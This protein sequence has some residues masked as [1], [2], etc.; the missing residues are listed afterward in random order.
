MNR[1]SDLKQLRRI[2][3][4]RQLTSDFQPIVNLRQVALF[5]YEGLIR[6]PADSSLHNPGSLFDCAGRHNLI[7]DLER[8][9]RDVSC[10]RFC[11]QSVNGKL[12]LNVSPVSISD[13]GFREH[14]IS[15]TLA[16]L[17]MPP[18]RMV[19]EIT[20]QYPLDDYQAIREATRY[21]KE[22]G[23]E[24]AIDDLGAGYAGLRT[25]S[26]LRP[27]YVKID[28]HFIEGIDVDPIKREFVRSIRKIAHELNCKV[29]AEGIETAGELSVILSL[30]IDFGQ[31]FFIGRPAAIPESPACIEARIDKPDGEHRPRRRLSQTVGDIALTVPTIAGNK[32][33]EQV[34]DLFH[35]DS[36]LTSLPVVDNDRVTGIVKRQDILALMAARYS[37]ELHGNRPI[38]Q[39]MDTEPVYVEYEQSLE[40][41]SQRLT[42]SSDTDLIQDFIILNNGEY[43]GI[44]KTSTLLK[45]ITEQ[46]LHYARYANPLTLLPGNLPI[47]EHLNNALGR[48]L[49]V[50]VAYIDLN[51]FKPYNDYYG[52]D[53]GDRIL[54]ALARILKEVVEPTRDFLGH[55]GGD[56]FII[57]FG[58]RDWKWRCKRVL[59]LFAKVAPD[60]Y[61]AVAVARGGIAG[62]NRRGD[63]EFF[64]LISVAI[65]VV[66]PDPVH[67]ASGHDVATLAA[68]AKQQAKARAGNSLFISRRRRPNSIT[69]D[70]ADTPVT[71]TLTT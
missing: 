55:V 52:Y 7:V 6:G 44:G 31:G 71:G 53:A 46:H 67:C 2:I 30:D 64:D 66:Q 33:L 35:D 4:E 13:S 5:G 16:P 51:N 58:S 45:R 32:P 11:E 70:R 24:I 63:E 34:V 18:G 62:R 40:T 14:F 22:L 17:S 60:F 8:A 20:E 56:D 43:H 15:Q 47:H 29:I 26:E 9:C 41:V 68:E 69:F 21:F 3:D 38:A 61:D 19:I 59:T 10:Q 23:F 27:H 12:F 36:G 1:V 37:R 48:H 39:F 57:I 28:R 42:E 54:V 49:D 50:H 25:W 65:G